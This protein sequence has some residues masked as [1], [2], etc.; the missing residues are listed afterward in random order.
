MTRAYSTEEP[1]AAKV[2]A[3]SRTVGIAT[4]GGRSSRQLTP[5]RTT[6]LDPKGGRDRSM[7]LKRGGA[8]DVYAPALQRLSD[9]AKAELPEPQCPGVECAHSSVA[10]LHADARESQRFHFRRWYALLTGRWLMKP[11]KGMSAEPTSL[12]TFRSDGTWDGLRGA[13][14]K[15]TES[16]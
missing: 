7:L 8:E 14:P 15:A 11:L 13:S 4:T 16:Q 6:Y 12:S 10:R 3:M 9:R 2:C 1:C 5:R